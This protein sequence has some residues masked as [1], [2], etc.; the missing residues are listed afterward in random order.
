MYHVHILIC[1]YSSMTSICYCIKVRRTLDYTYASILVIVGII[2]TL[3]RIQSNSRKHI[4]MISW[5]LITIFSRAIRFISNAVWCIYIT[6]IYIYIYMLRVLWEYS[7]MS[8]YI[9][10]NSLAQRQI[11]R[12][13]ADDNFKWKLISQSA[14]FCLLPWCS[15]LS[16][17]RITWF[18]KTYNDKPVYL[19]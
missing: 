2:T 9:Y 8:P 19:I 16:A 18:T 12:Y 14:S 1:T 7:Y 3:T 10:L 11:G 13:F 17:W 5:S 15:T 4:F 6:N